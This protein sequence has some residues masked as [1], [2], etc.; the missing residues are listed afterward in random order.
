MRSILRGYG[1]ELWDELEENGRRIRHALKMSDTDWQT[2]SGQLKYCIDTVEQLAP[3]LDLPQHL[4]DEIKRVTARYRMR[5]TPYY[6]SL[7]RRDRGNDPVLLQSVPTGE[8][9]DNVGLEM[10]PVAA[11]QFSG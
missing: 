10:P 11:D 9:T 4:V 5:L 7:I 2:Y 8:M 1:I 3:I 6:A